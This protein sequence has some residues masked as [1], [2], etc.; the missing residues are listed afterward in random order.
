MLAISLISLDAGCSRAASIST[1]S[2]D[3]AAR[4]FGDKV[5]TAAFIQRNTAQ[6]VSLFAPDVL[7]NIQPSSINQL[8]LRFSKECGALKTFSFD[9]GLQQSRYDATQQRTVKEA[10]LTYYG[11]CSNQ[12]RARMLIEVGYDRTW[13]LLLLSYDMM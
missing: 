7:T 6:V 1:N 3:L 9:T 12:R 5:V 11:L 2:V 10:R 13:W 4:Q 8:I